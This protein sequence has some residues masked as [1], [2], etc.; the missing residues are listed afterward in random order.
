MI[1]EDSAAT[2]EKLYIKVPNYPGLYR[3]TVSGRYYG[4]KKLRG[5]RKERSLG[6]TDRKIAER[7][8]KEWVANLDKVDSEVEKTTLRQ[9]LARFKAIT[10]GRVQNTQVTNDAIIN[11]FLKWWPLGLD[12]Q[13]RHVRP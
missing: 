7:R 8:M 3:H 12:A 4:V 1:N 10:Q 2:P 9:L 11:H 6:T 13:V 5:R